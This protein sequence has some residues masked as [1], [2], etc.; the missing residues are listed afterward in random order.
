MAIL[1]FKPANC[2]NC[3]RCLRECPV[4]AIQIADNGAQIIE[5]YCILCGR[6]TRVC[7][8]NA[9]SVASSIAN[10]KKFL[11]SS[12]KVIASVAP[13]FIANYAVDGFQPLKKALMQLGFVDC[14]ETAEGAQIVTKE[15]QK[16]IDSNQYSN[17][18]STACPSVV[19]LV[20]KYYPNAL[21]YLAPVD[22]PMVAHAKLLHKKFGDDIKVIFIGPCIAKKKEALKANELNNKILISDVLTFEELSELLNEKN[23]EFDNALVDEKDANA[24]RYYAINRGIIKSFQ[25][26]NPNY[27]YISVDGISNTRQVLDNIDD[28]T[29]V[30][31]EMNSC[32][33]SCVNGPASTHDNYAVIKAVEKVR[34][35]TRKRLDKNQTPAFETIDVKN[36]IEHLNVDRKIPDEQTIKKLL[37]K[38]NK[39]KP[40]DELNCAACGYQTCRDKAIAVYNG[41]SNIY[42][43][44]PYMKE[45]AEKMN[46]EV[47]Y[48]SPNGII[49]FDDEQNIININQ[50][51]KEIFG[52]IN[53]ETSLGYFRD[54]LPWDD[55]SFG[56]IEHKNIIE[57]QSYIEK[58]KRYIEFS[59]IFVKDHHMS[60][61][62]VKD[63]TQNVE[64]K[65]QIM[66]N[67]IDLVETTNKVI[68]KQMRV[69]QEIA[70]LLGETTA[71]TKVA[72]IKLRDQFIKKDGE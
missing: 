55:L 50:K 56:F 41:L 47:I 28:L 23:I 33:F 37:A 19:S 43:C 71:E 34:K 6:C 64:Y 45:M 38:I 30:F 66:K 48:Y 70:S 4:K 46:Q 29:G 13:S 72:L 1:E 42:T 35:Y 59:L 65:D 8:Q 32:D 22:S 14:F 27:E 39:F 68:D 49:T 31:F 11:N 21:K 10:V 26:F 44:L 69:V 9:K 3:Y 15:Y 61:C 17:I 53:P 58:T 36:T 12:A 57:K 25:D 52:I 62:L 40:E 20:R 2:K 67:R 63:V 51:A 5:E 24:A 7:N 60:F 16:L 18:I 54:Y